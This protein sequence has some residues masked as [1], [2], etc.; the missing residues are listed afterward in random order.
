MCRLAT[1]MTIKSG[2]YSPRWVPIYISSE[3][4]SGVFLPL[5]LMNRLSLLG[6]LLHGHESQSRLGS[7]FGIGLK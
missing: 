3:D 4:E 2:D 1:R 7:E 6:Y 5:G